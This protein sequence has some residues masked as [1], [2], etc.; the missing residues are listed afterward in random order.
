M[1]TTIAPAADGLTAARTTSPSA[2]VLAVINARASR[3]HDA[4][5]LRRA[6]RGALV[7][8]GA[9]ADAVTTSSLADLRDALARA[10][11]RRV[12]LVGGDG[13]L[14]AVAN[15]GLALPELALVP[16]GRANNIARALGIPTTLRDAARVAVRGAARPLDALEVRT[17]GRSL[18]AVEG[19]SAGLH[20]AGRMRYEGENSGSVTQGAIAL[21]QTLREL[22]RYETRLALDDAPPRTVALGQLFLSTLPYFAFGLRVDPVADVRDGVA[23]AILLRAASRRRA[24]RLLLAARS[25]HH[26]ELEG[27][28]LS[29]WR[30]AE[31]PDPVPLTADAEPLGMTTASIAV[32]PGALRVATGTEA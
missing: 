16:A 9:S 7:A 1:S 5:N 2:S 11:G 10:D 8:E 3:V 30:R 14:H 28:E 31:L 22:P 23:E 17:P 18:V 19:V 13:A 21:A 29:R 20:A 4:E 15:L 6:V 27:V 12:V 24:L 32:L 26:L 25:G